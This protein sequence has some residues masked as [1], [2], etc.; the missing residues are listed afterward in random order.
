MRVTVNPEAQASGDFGYAAPGTYTLR[1]VGCTQKQSAGKQFPYLEWKFEFAD[2][3]VPSVEKNGDGSSKKLG[4]I[5][6]IT[7]LKPDAQ[8]ALRDVCEAMGLTW[9]DFD[10]D[11]VKGLEASAQVKLETYND[12]IKNVVGAWKKR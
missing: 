12:K 2:P 11:E 8:F 3:N 9:G 6:E 7:T 10:T 1:C 4:N 5:F